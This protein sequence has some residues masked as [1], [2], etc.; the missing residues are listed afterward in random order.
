MVDPWARGDGEKRTPKESNAR[1]DNRYWKRM[2]SLDRRSLLRASLAWAAPPALL[3]SM[4]GCSKSSNNLET[5][6]STQSMLPSNDLRENA[7]RIQYL[8]IVT[9]DMD[10]VCSQYSN[11]MGVEFSEPIQELGGARTASLDGGGI[12][13]IRKP[14]R[15]NELPVVRPYLLVENIERSVA[16]AAQL[17]AT[18]ALPPMMLPGH[19][20]CA[21]VIQGGIECG[22]WQ[23]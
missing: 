6:D 14:L 8:E 19:G 4:V 2:H 20:I 23:L 10:G 5:H 3:Y 15:E 1:P 21:I 22:L 12:L 17:G 13:G 18:V 11:V 16:E 7:M 9:P